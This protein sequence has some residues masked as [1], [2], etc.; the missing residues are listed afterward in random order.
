MVKCTFAGHRDVVGIKAA[1]VEMA[2]EH[3]I[4]KSAAPME[5]LVGGMGRFDDICASAVRSL[6]R[7]YRD[8]EISLVLVL[9]YMQKR[10]NEN[11]EYYETMFDLILIPSELERVYYKRAIVLRNRWMV[12]QAD[13]VIAAV[14]R[15]EG[16]AY[17]ALQYAQKKGKRIINLAGFEK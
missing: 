9:P 8:R 4:Q 5:C 10:V 6:K 12:E 1:D 13:Y 7:R 11:K 2:L 15:K 16:G 3:I 17:A 14:R